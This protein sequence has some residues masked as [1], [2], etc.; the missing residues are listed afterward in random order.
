MDFSHFVSFSLIDENNTA[1]EIMNA[2][3]TFTVVRAV[4]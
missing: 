3:E 4:Q 1:K 2:Y